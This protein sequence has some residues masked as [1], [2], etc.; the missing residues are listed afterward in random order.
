MNEIAFCAYLEWDLV[1]PLFND[2]E[3]AHFCLV[4]LDK[5]RYFDNGF[6]FFN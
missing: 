2:M 3:I 6:I 4:N 5:W 1:V